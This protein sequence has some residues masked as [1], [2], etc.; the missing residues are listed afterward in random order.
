MSEIL[1]F[2][3][4]K[5]DN[6]F[7]IGFY[8]GGNF[9]DEMLLEINLNFFKK[10]DS[11]NVRFYYQNPEIYKNLHKDFGYDLIDGRSYKSIF[12]ALI[13]S[14]NII[15]GGGG[16]WGMDFNFRNFLFSLMIF[17]AR[18]FLLKKVFLIGV[19]FY[20]STTFLGRVGAF[21]AGISAN[22]IIARDDE[23][24]KNFSRFS[25]KVVQDFDLSFY[26]KG[27]DDEIY[28]KDLQELKERFVH[29]LENENP[30]ERKL[31][32]TTRRFIPS[33]KN[34]FNEVVQSFV[35]KNLDKKILFLTLEPK[36][37]DPIGF[38]FIKNLS[39]K[40]E[41]FFF[42]DFSFNPLSF[43]FF[44]QKNSKNF[45]VIAPQFHMIISAYLS[46]CGFFPMYY[47]NKVKEL[48][49]IINKKNPIKI[50]DLKED[51]LQKFVEK[52]D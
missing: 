4:N 29:F 2:Y 50:E 27:F 51:D 13:K 30:K 48:F 10:T 3:K 14:K 39:S 43:L 25:K 9:G 45:A 31:I 35:E 34:N 5:L 1:N 21:F 38:E 37:I 44:L 11:K 26:A 16:I 41:N 19:G 36:E 33:K 52:I 22:L 20:N 23:T 46:G 28:K 49:K 8:G 42:S 12:F 47:D 32:I 7:L 6:T 15:V 17:F 24:K 40:S 18:F